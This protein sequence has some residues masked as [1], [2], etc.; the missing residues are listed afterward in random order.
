VYSNGYS[1]SHRVVRLFWEVVDEMAAPQR[2]ALLRF[3]T[4]SSRAP[5]GGFR[6]LHPPFTLHRVDCG[7]RNPL[8]G[9]VGRDIELLPSARCVGGRMSLPHQ[10]A[11]AAN[12]PWSPLP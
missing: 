5:L 10:L 6:H 11:A 12:P 4:S 9:I 7:P 1:D 8:A 3:V 2:A